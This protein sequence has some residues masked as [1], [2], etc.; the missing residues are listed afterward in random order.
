MDTRRRVE[1]TH[2]T[3]RTHTTTQDT[4]HTT[5]TDTTTHHN[6]TTTTPHGHRHRE[7][8]RQGDKR[9]RKRR[10]Q[11][12]RGEMREIHFQCGGAWPFFVGE[13]ICLVTPFNDRFLSLPNS[14]KYDSSLTSFSASWPVNS[15]FLYLRKNYSIQLQFAVFLCF[16]GYA[17]TFSKFSELFSYAAT[18]FFCRN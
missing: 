15:F 3:H 18:V 13:V 8:Q 14:V 17:V 4:T 12:N 2:T 9:R 1:W 7:R 10:R 6:N 5:T 16:L 11:E